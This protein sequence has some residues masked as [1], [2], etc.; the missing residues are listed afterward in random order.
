MIQGPRG[1][2]LRL[3]GGHGLKRAWLMM[4]WG[5]GTADAHAVWACS[6]RCNGP[7][8]RSTVRTRRVS[9]GWLSCPEKQVISRMAFFLCF[10][11]RVK[12]KRPLVRFGRTLTRIEPAHRSAPQSTSSGRDL[13]HKKKSFRP[14]RTRIHGTLPSPR[15]DP[16]AMASDGGPAAVGRSSSPQAWST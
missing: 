4:G 12:N 15:S 11:S 9:A 13:G 1:V 2:D 7:R 5:S 10:F 8:V 14:R 3:H 6:T 16:T